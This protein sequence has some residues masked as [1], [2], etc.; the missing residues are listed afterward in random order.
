[1][2]GP[3]TAPAPCAGDTQALLLPARPP[4]S[5][6]R[7]H[8]RTPHP[9]CEQYQQG[10]LGAVPAC[11]PPPPGPAAGALCPPAA[12]RWRPW[13]RTGR[14]SRR[15]S[16]WT[17]GPG[18]PE[19]RPGPARARVCV[20]VW[21]GRGV[22]ERAGCRGWHLFNTCVH[23]RALARHPL[24]R[25]PHATTSGLPKPAP[26]LRCPFA[27]FCEHAHMCAPS[28]PSAAP[29]P[30]RSSLG[31]APLRGANTDLDHGFGCADET[32]IYCQPALLDRGPQRPPRR[33]RVVRVEAGQC[34][35]RADHLGR[36]RLDLQDL[37]SWTARTMQSSQ[38][39]A[40]DGACT[41]LEMAPSANR[42]RFC[43]WSLTWHGPSDCRTFLTFLA[44]PGA[45]EAA[46]IFAASSCAH[47][48]PSS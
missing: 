32:L 30:T 25:S 17:A 6:P 40:G 8:T 31:S 37:R 4:P 47:G 38:Q 16:C 42:R 24:T 3:L 41:A 13:W 48:A 44:R 28:A 19:P 35:Q 26:V 7:T 10:G 12:A 36:L 39:P 22:G 11:A 21:Q 14:A 29:R 33:G 45:R 15:R 43:G 23:A 27:S 20:R 5:P 46:A 9:H 18:S 34:L 1:M 2:G